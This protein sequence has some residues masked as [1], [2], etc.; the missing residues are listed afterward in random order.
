MRGVFAGDELTPGN[1]VPSVGLLV[2]GG[3]GGELDERVMVLNSLSLCHFLA[4]LTTFCRWL[5]SLRTFS[6]CIS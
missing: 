5:G 3:G 6:C 4:L 2:A 1:T